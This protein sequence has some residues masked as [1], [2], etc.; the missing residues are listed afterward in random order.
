[1]A[2]PA[3]DKSLQ[4]QLQLLDI[5]SCEFRSGEVPDPGGG[6]GD[7]G[8]KSQLQRTE[9]PKKCAHQSSSSSGNTVRKMPLSGTP[10]ATVLAGNL[11]SNSRNDKDLRKTA[12][13]SSTKSSERN[14]TLAYLPGSVARG[15][16]HFP[17]A[18]CAATTTAAAAPAAA[19]A[20]VGSP[21]HGCGACADVHIAPAHSAQGFAAKGGQL[22]AP[23]ES[24]DAA[25]MAE[26]LQ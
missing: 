4:D 2:S 13:D 1:M 12:N 10:T 11:Y 20:S 8:A 6:D 14:T 21:E 26:E 19:V 17:A 3:K 24:V 9:T 18:E 15:A 5:S 22:R 7:D 25:A 16:Q 23:L